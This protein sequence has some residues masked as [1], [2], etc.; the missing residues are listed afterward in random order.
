MDEHRTSVTMLLTRKKYTS[1]DRYQCHLVHQV[2]T[3][4]ASYPA[5]VATGLNHGGLVKAVSQSSTCL[6]LVVES[7]HS[8]DSEVTSGYIHNPTLSYCTV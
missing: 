8:G 7:R 2:R 3:G 1:T 4:M 5:S 6:Q